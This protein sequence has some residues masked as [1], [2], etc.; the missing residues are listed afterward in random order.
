MMDITTEIQ[1]KERCDINKSDYRSSDILTLTYGVW[2]PHSRDPERGLYRVD[3][4]VG[5]VTV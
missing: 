4:M 1:T 3:P 2:R 5:A